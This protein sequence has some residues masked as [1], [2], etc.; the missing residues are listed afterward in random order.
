MA[1]RRRKGPIRTLFKRAFTLAML[2]A[3]VYAVLV[4]YLLVR[5]HNVPA[6]YHP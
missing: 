4:A 5:E 3:L 1:R 2:F 6:P